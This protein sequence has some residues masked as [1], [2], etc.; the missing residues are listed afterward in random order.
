[1]FKNKVV[2]TICL[3]FLSVEG[4]LKDVRRKILHVIILMGHFKLSP[5]LF[6]HGNWYHTIFFSL[7][8]WREVKKRFGS[9][10]LELGTFKWKCGDYICEPTKLWAQI[11]TYQLSSKICLPTNGLKTKCPYFALPLKTRDFSS[12]FFHPCTLCRCCCWHP[13][14]TLLLCSSSLSSWEFVCCHQKA[15]DFPQEEAAAVQVWTQGIIQRYCFPHIL[16][17]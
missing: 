1:M 17:F 11:R 9:N 16:S 4:D 6:F 3:H 15:A 14:S 8:L 10:L 12:S 13:V 7:W 5:L 2:L